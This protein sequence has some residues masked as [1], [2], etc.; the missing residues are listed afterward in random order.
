MDLVVGATGLLGTQICRLLRDSGREV[1][2]LVRKSSDPVKVS[3]LRGLGVELVHG[4]L[5]QPS[6][7]RAACL[8]VDAV[9]ATATSMLSRAEGDDIPSVDGRGNLDLIAAASAAQSSHFVFTSFCPVTP[10]FPLQRVKRDAERALDAGS[11]PWTVLQPSHFLEVWFSP[12]LG[13]DVD[14]GTARV[15]ASGQRPLQWVSYMDVARVAVALVAAGPQRR[16]LAFGGPK[17]VSQRQVIA[18]FERAGGKPFSCEDVTEATLRAQYDTTKNALDKS[19]AALQL[20][21]GVGEPQRLDNSC[22]R[23]VYDKP[24][25]SV[26]DFVEEET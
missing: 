9:I 2:G 25:K 12:R 5:K 8:G 23:G 7:L 1:R 13:F 18:Q 19:F 20:A 16:V 6:S 11:M 14:G 10:D 26:E 4:D 3:T 22:L 17:A 15:Y 24:L 21:C